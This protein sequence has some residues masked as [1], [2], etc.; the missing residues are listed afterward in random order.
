MVTDA[1]Q[2]ALDALSVGGLY[3]LTAIGI[4][5]IF[6]VMRLINFA[7]SELITTAAYVLFLL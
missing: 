5:L 1:L 2:I 3:A 6:S 4:G 7:H